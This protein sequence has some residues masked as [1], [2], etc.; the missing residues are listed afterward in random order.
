MPYPTS[1]TIKHWLQRARDLHQQPM[2]IVDLNNRGAEALRHGNTQVAMASLSQALCATNVWLRET[3]DAV[4]AGAAAEIVTSH[5][6]SSSSQ[7]SQGFN[8]DELMQSPENCETSDDDMDCVDDKPESPY[9]LSSSSSSSSSS[10][11]H[12]PLSPSSGEQSPPPA[13]ATSFSS[14]DAAYTSPIIIPGTL[15]NT[16]RTIQ[17]KEEESEHQLPP[18]PGS[19]L[20]SIIIFNLALAYH[21]HAVSLGDAAHRATYL[22]KAKA[23]YQL[24]IKSQEPQIS[25]S[26]TVFRM[27]FMYSVN[28]LGVVHRLLGDER[29]ANICFQRLLTVLMFLKYCD[30]GKSYGFSWFFHNLFRS[31]ENSM[32]P[33]A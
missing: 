20:S 27:F 25:S 4:E 23:L 1:T 15:V 10:R 21:M 9:S 3:H 33:A 26:N 2:V 28:N 22:K 29:S 24:A 8:I 6:S 5:R 17:D 18:P 13:A 7:S 30:D 32:A 12:T 16:N 31:A 19:F 11:L 14:A